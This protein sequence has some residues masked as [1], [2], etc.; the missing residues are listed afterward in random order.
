MLQRSQPLAFAF[1]LCASLAAAQERPR[2]VED[3]LKQAD[4]L[5]QL[6]GAQHVQ[7]ETLYEQ[8]LALAPEDPEVNLRMGMCQLNGPFRHKA[9][10]YLLRA[11]E[12]DPGLPRINYLVGYAHHLN[13]E[14][15]PAIAAFEAH[16]KVR[17]VRDTDPRYN[18][19]DDHLRQCRNGRSLSAKPLPVTVRNLGAGINSSATDHG[20]LITGDGR[21]LYFTSRRASTM[22]AKVNKITGEYFEQVFMVHR[23]DAGWG[24][25][26]ELPAPLNSPENDAGV[27]LAAD[28]S[29]IILYRDRTGAGD[30]YESRWNGSAWGAPTPLGE[31]INS[32]ANESAA[33]RTADGQW[34]YFASDRPDDNVGGQDILR[35][36]WNPATLSWGAP[37]N[38]G[39]T[40]NSRLDEDGVFIS[41]DGTTLYFSSKG[42]TS[43]GGYDIFRSRLVDGQWTKPENLGWPINS[44]EDDLFFVLTDDGTRGYFSSLRADG[45]GEDDIH[46]VLFGRE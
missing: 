36:R 18:D 7:A 20:P 39:P 1:L 14:W 38:L 32:D 22:N 33:W 27:G 13:A 26:Q 28:G 46:E 44:P 3:L 25:P 12:L 42:H 43:M 9:L 45:L 19:A 11:R 35:A 17:D 37:E 5:A 29:S 21:T 16:K 34:L 15:D 4:K 30:L 10:P 31:P 41:R 40:V 6:G 23:D 24:T 8:A 2:Q